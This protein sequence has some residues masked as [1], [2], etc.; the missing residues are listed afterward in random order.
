MDRFVLPDPCLLFGKF[1]VLMGSRI[2]PIAITQGATV[3]P[4]RTSRITTAQ[5]RVRA[6]TIGEQPPITDLHR[7]ST[8]GIRQKTGIETGTDVN[9]IGS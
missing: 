8:T 6:I 5:D 3:I 4:I 7:H 9:P 1:P 2:F